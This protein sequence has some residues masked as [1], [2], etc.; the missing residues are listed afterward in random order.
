M[1]NSKFTLFITS[2]L[3]LCLILVGCY[4]ISNN[5]L[6]FD[7]NAQEYSDDEVVVKMLDEN[8]N[9]QLVPVTETYF[10]GQGTS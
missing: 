7:S 8:G 9:V 10:E 4:M 1:F 5:N 2:I 3:I 6:E